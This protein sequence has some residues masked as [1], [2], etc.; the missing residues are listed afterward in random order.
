MAVKKPTMPSFASIISVLSIVFYCAGFLRVELELHEHK[1]RIN[2]LE[3]VA[4]AKPPSN[5]PDIIKNVPA[6]HPY[7][8]RQS[9]QVESTKNESES[10]SAVE[11][12]IKINKQLSELRLHLCQ[13]KHVT[14]SSG[15]PGPPGPPGPRGHKGARGRR[16]QKGRNGNKGD[17]GIMG[18]P[19]ESGKRGIVGPAG[20][21]GETGL[22]GA[23]GDIGPAGMPGSKGEPGESISSPAVVV[24]PVTLTVNEG[25]SA[26][27]QC[28]AS[29]N[30]EPAVVWSKLDNQSEITQSALSRG[31][32]QLTKVTG[33]DSGVY[34]CSA[35]NILGN[36]REVVRLAVNVHPH[37]SLHPGPSYVTEGSNVTLPIC[38]VTGYP[39]PVVTW[40]KSSGQLPQ[41]RA[42]YNKS[43]LQISD[44]RKVD[45]DTYFCSAVNLLGNVERKTQLVVISLP[46][47]TV[48]PPGKVAV[49]FGDTLTLNC[50][51]TGDPQ[52]VI[53]WKRQG[54]TLPVGRSHRTNEALVLKDF[55]KVDAGIY[56]CVA[57]SAGVFDIERVTSV[58][59]LP[60]GTDCSDLLKSGH[61]QSG[62]YSINPDGRGHFTVYCDMRTDGGGWTVF[63]RRQDGSVDFYRGWNDYKAGFGQ[64]AA[65][66]WLGN[67]KIHRLTAYKPSTLRVELEDWSGGKAY[68]KYGKF[69]IGDEQANYRLEVGSYS[70]TAGDSLA[71]H[72]NM[73]FTTK[74]SDNDIDSSR[75]CAVSY[76]GA[77]WYHSCHYSNLNGQYLGDKRDWRGILWRHFRSPLSL[78]FTEMKLRPSS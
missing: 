23:K 44:V 4:E 49:D 63:Q 50:S 38:H 12:M 66:F 40:R 72:N 57:T 36:S 27:F 45:S 74:D 60:S 65:E 31:K 46:V 54:A 58:E 2:A 18:S 24:S 17:K 56:I 48:K 26:S 7:K 62:L 13:S 76:T 42:Q 43:V 75:N 39:A 78:R 73:A 34:Q 71:Y 33:N 16:G 1:K 61:T 69:N 68:A 55:R 30:P 25:G 3:S 22:K 47:F 11:T 19:G 21:K 9:R 51:A 14:C 28:S 64:L 15:P 41:G 53:S 8:H 29:G 20:I 32:L 35:T 77:W 10:K 70:G 67:D 37:V 6:I 59:A 52:P 5:D